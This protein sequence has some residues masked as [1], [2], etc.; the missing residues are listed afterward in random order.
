MTFLIGSFIRD[1]ET[2]FKA[3]VQL[4]NKKNISK[5]NPPHKQ[6]ENYEEENKELLK[7][8]KILCTL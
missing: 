5:M 7:K 1:H 8:K 4:N 6:N 3:N 2:V